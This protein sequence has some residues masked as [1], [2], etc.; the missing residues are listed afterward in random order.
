MKSHNRKLVG[1]L[2]LSFTMS[3][4]TVVAGLQ[5]D[6]QQEIDNNPFMKEQGIKIRV[7][8]EAGY[9]TLEVAEGNRQVRKIIYQGVDISTI[10]GSAYMLDT[11]D[12]DKSAC[13]TLSTINR[14][15]QRIEKMDGVKE[16]AVKALINT[17]HDQLADKQ[18]ELEAIYSQALRHY[19][20]GRMD[21]AFILFKQAADEGHTNSQFYV[22]AMY[23]NGQGVPT[24]KSGI[25]TATP[26]GA[27]QVT[28]ANATQLLA[29]FVGIWKGKGKYKGLLKTVDCTIDIAIQT[30]AQLFWTATYEQGKKA[31][32]NYTIVS[33][34]QNGLT[35]TYRDSSIWK[36]LLTVTTNDTRQ[37]QIA[38]LEDHWIGD[39]QYG[40]KVYGTIW[41]NTYQIQRVQ[42]NLTP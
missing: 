1:L 33:A 29:P 28:K 30:N 36:L 38:S 41:S 9:V 10:A 8:E 2:A 31:M 23:Q 11:L 19:E 40:Q 5:N 18:N 25:S 3:V 37:A 42:D 7:A 15:I 12:F 39:N 22:D 4:L 13:E 20:S 14:T 16:V 17:E 27:I 21:K 32:K 24:S 35:A 6:I 34:D 26:V